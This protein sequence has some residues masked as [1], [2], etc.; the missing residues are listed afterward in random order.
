MVESSACDLGV[1]QTAATIAPLIGGYAVTYLRVSRRTVFSSSA[2]IIVVTLLLVWLFYQPPPLERV[3]AARAEKWFILPDKRIFSV[4][5]VVTLDAFSWG[6]S[7]TQFWGLYIFEVM[8]AT[9]EQ[10]AIAI[11]ISTGVQ[12]LSG[13]TL[14]SRLDR[15]GRRPFLA[16]SEWCA[17]GAVLPLLLGWRVEFE[18]ISA[19]F[20]GLVTSLWRPA[21]Y[22][23]VV[24]NFGREKFGRTLG[25]LLL[26]SGAVGATAS[27]IG[28][29]MW[30]NVSP[31]L[32]FMT[33][34]LLATITGIVIWFKLKEKTNDST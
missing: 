14:G 29:L 30:D 12:A 25:L 15:V 16:F 24:E 4:L 18:Y 13:F 6:M 23:Y 10:L 8:N 21:L 5:V 28:G 31:K 34:M 32:P 27:L 17:V 1:T 2:A 20:W 3:G 22:A 19:L 33:T 11:A 26:V 7:T 9:Q